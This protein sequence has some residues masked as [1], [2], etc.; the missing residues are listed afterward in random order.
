MG[1]IALAIIWNGNLALT[2]VSCGIWFLYDFFYL[3][4]KS[5]NTQ[6]LSAPDQTFGQLPSNSATIRI[7]AN[8]TIYSQYIM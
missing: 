7:G 8:P 1:P 2:D 5:V 4:F 6:N 3:I